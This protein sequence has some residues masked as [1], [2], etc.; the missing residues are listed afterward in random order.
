M[1]SH[2]IEE[3]EMPNDKRP[4]TARYLTR[5]PWTNEVAALVGVHRDN[6]RWATWMAYEGRREMIAASTL[7]DRSAALASAREVAP[8]ADAYFATIVA[9]GGEAELRAAEVAF[10]EALAERCTCG[11]PN[12]AGDPNCPVCR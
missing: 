6:V 1:H 8:F 12:L 3:T 2:P 10:E 5:N 4:E 7:D 11:D 9:E